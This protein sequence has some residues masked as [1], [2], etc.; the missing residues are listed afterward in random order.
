MTDEAPDSLIPYDEIVQDAL[1]AVVGR[2]LGEVEEAGSLP[3]AHHFYITFRT[4]APG[5]DI[6]KHQPQRLTEE[7]T[8]SIKNRIRDPKIYEDRFEE[9]EKEA[10]RERVSKYGRSQ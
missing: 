9:E 1:R 3:G 7:M 8:I 2:V 5:E 6:P 4:R 10:A